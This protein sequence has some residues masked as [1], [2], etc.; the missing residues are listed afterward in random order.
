[1]YD[2][3]RNLRMRWGATM[4]IFS[5]VCLIA[6]VLTLGVNDADAQSL[7]YKSP[8]SAQSKNIQPQSPNCNTTLPFSAFVGKKIVFLAKTVQFQKYGYST[9]HLPGDNFNS[10]SYQ[11]YAGKVGTIVSIDGSKGDDTTFKDV[12]VRM[13]ESG[14]L[15]TNQA[16]SNSI[17]DV[18][19]LD[20]IQYAKTQYVGKTFWI[21]TR[22]VRTT[23]DVE[24]YDGLKVRKYSAVKIVDAVPGAFQYDPIDLVVETE[25]HQNVLVPTMTSL[26]NVSSDMVTSLSKSGR[27]CGFDET[28]LTENPRLAHKWP[29]AVW[30][31]IEQERVV[32]G[33]NLEQVI[34]A[35]GEPRDF[36]ETKTQNTY[37]AQLVYGE[38]VYIYINGQ[39]IVTAVQE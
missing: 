27:A 8:T 23:Q 26:T 14:K 29:E 34:L 33:M 16:L 39:N 6:T 3:L 35:K 9:W 31:N 4:G 15:V 24:T 18:V 13:D 12:V 21:K 32:V 36:N 17:S 28:F 22:L 20:D 1:M 38:N 2:V 37:S 5:K 10:P 30:R 7:L 25:T 19:F 11:E